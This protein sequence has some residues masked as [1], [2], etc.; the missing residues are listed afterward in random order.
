MAISLMT[1]QE[2]ISARFDQSGD[3][4]SAT[5]D[6]WTKRRRLINEAEGSW[7][8]F[9]SGKWNALLTSTSITTASGQ[10]YVTLPTDYSQGSALIPS[11]GVYTIGTQD[12]QVVSKEDQLTYNSTDYLV[13]FTGNDPSGY[14]MNIQPTPTGNTQITFDYYSNYTAT[15]ST[16]VT[17]KQELTLVDDESKLPDPTYIVDYVLGELFTID[18]EEGKGNRYAAR[19]QSKLIEMAA[20]DEFGEVN[21]QVNLTD[22]NEALGFEPYGGSEDWR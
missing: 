18:D 21:Q 17:S 1:L 8:D 6:E 20:L 7:R 5:T 9:K 12:Y 22:T 11:N 10:A 3:T 19:A 14:R 15:D 4:I 13:W 2:R 16:G